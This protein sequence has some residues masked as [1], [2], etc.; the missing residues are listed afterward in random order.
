MGRDFYRS[1]V[2]K[3]YISSKTWPNSV[4]YP[5]QSSFGNRQSRYLPKAASCW[6]EVKHLWWLLALWLMEH[7]RAGIAAALPSRS[8]WE[9]VAGGYC[10]QVKPWSDG[11]HPTLLASWLQ[12]QKF[13]LVCTLPSS[14]PLL[15]AFL[16][17][18]AQTNLQPLSWG[19]RTFTSGKPLYALATTL[20]KAFNFRKSL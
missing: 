11:H 19:V 15:L 4:S 1:P 10:S 17:R 5:R 2:H 7:R 16:F 13:Q 3:K 12:E 18:C 20:K 6:R 9:G 14:T 8:L